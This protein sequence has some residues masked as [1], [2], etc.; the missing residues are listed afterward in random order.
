[1]AG[2]HNM[3]QKHSEDQEDYSLYLIES[4]RILAEIEDFASKRNFFMAKMSCHSLTKTIDKMWSALNK[5]Y[6]KGN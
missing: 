2:D 1:M 3:N 6:N 4:R 5:Q